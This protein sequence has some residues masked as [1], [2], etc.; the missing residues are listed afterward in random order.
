LGGLLGFLEE[1]CWL[2]LVG[3]EFDSGDGSVFKSSF[4]CA[5]WTQT[6]VEKRAYSRGKGAR[7]GRAVAWGELQQANDAHHA[8]C[9]SSGEI[10]KEKKKKGPG[11]LFFGRRLEHWKRLRG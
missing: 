9:N 5:S 4:R 1:I 2:Y 11:I 3:W 7:S 8:K 6:L 10:A